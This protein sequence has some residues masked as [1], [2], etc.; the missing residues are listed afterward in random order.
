MEIIG[1]L[2]GAV[3]SL[4]LVIY[5]VKVKHFTGDIGW[6]ERYFGPGG[7]FTALLLIGIAG[8]FVSLMV[9]TGTLDLLFGS[10][11]EKFFGGSK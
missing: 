3:L 9:M 6:A 5:R 2:I 8:F 1:G 4:L 10:V 7:T 11:G